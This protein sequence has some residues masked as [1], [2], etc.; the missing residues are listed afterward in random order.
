MA[1]D[2]VVGSSGHR[3]PG[4]IAAHGI[5]HFND[6]VAY[7][8]EVGANWPT[9]LLVII[10]KSYLS[11]SITSPAPVVCRWF[12]SQSGYQHGTT[13]DSPLTVAIFLLIHGKMT[14]LLVTTRFYHYHDASPLGTITPCAG[15]M[16]T[17]NVVW[18]A[19]S[20]YGTYASNN[21]HFE[22]YTY[23]DDGA[24]HILLPISTTPLTMN[25]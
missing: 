22:A 8:V 12:G 11:M 10:S 20:C 19:S 9:L 23:A 25:P 13:A 17:L 1:I 14:V 7:T 15:G 16:S 3:Y 21:A 18:L 5:F 2:W 6:I 24:E 4:M